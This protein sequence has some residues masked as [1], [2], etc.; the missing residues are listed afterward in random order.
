MLFLNCMSFISR[1]LENIGIT[2]V[3]ANSK[4]SQEPQFDINV[5][6]GVIRTK[7]TWEQLLTVFITTGNLG[8]YL[9]FAQ[10]YVHNYFELFRIFANFQTT[11]LFLLRF[12]VFPHLLWSLVKPLTSKI[13]RYRYNYS[14][15]CVD[16]DLLGGPI[17]Q[18]F[19]INK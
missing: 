19:S 9:A 5:P 7:A 1:S 11:C 3:E 13:T 14:I 10:N 4:I 15:L 6:T 2:H 17:P 18:M 12:Y 8:R 16:H